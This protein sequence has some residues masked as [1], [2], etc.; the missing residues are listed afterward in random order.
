MNCTVRVTNEILLL[1]IDAYAGTLSSQHPQVACDEFSYMPQAVCCI[2]IL[3]CHLFSITSFISLY[4][5]PI[6]VLQPFILLNI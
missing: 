3:T 1:I 4:V 5:F 6:L 2:T